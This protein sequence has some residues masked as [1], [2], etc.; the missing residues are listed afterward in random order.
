MSS[1]SP[2]ANTEIT[3]LQYVFL[4]YQA[5]HDEIFPS[6]SLFI[7]IYIIYV[8]EFLYYNKKN[9]FYTI[10]LSQNRFDITKI[11]NLNSYYCLI[12]L[13]IFNKQVIELNI[14]TLLQ[15]ITTKPLKTGDCYGNVNTVTYLG[16]TGYNQK[17]VLKR[18]LQ[19]CQK[20]CSPILR[21]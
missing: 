9:V 2:T 5:K 15:R 12:Y 1:N 4:E 19:N 21:A 3:I 10:S 13:C 17:Y 18:T 16:F 6:L 11:L 7:Y 8:I 14:L 20:I